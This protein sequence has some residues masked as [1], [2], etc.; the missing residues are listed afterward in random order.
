MDSWSKR[1]INIAQC[2]VL[3]NS[4]EW[5]LDRPSVAYLLPVSA[6][7]RAFVIWGTKYTDDKSS[8]SQKTRNTARHEGNCSYVDFGNSMFSSFRLTCGQYG[9]ITVT[10]TARR[11]L[12][13][14]RT[15]ASYLEVRS[16]TWFSFIKLS[17][18]RRAVTLYTTEWSSA[19]EISRVYYLIDDP[20]FPNLLE[21]FTTH[22]GSLLNRVRPT[23]VF[24]G[25]YGPV[26]NCDQN[27]R[28][29]PA[30]V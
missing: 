3:V 8:T 13:T 29:L 2:A 28:V 6:S 21:H 19:L 17:D 4:A 9:I 11:R 30:K 12:H 26:A 24:R 25:E 27:K 10:C 7:S 20:A 16:L 22:L 15:W 5:A 18:E 1:L 14:W 23:R